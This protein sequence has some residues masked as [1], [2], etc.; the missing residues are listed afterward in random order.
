MSIFK[1]HFKLYCAI[2]VVLTGLMLSACQHTP[3]QQGN[4]PLHEVSKESLWD[5]DHEVRYYQTPLSK[6]SYQLEVVANGR[7]RFERLATFLMRISYQLCQGYGYQLKVLDGV[8]S[9][10]HY[11]ASPNLIMG[12]LKARLECPIS[13]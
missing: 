1:K 11:R 12:N 2:I 6:S 5:F 10:D 9:Y 7:V 4:K 13:Q 8:E 3:A